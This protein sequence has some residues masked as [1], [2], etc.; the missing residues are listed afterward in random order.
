ML[1]KNVLLDDKAT[2]QK[3]SYSH[4]D[5]VLRWKI[6]PDIKIVF[7]IV[8]KEIL[9]LTLIDEFLEMLAY[10]FEQKVWPKLLL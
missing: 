4:S 2:G 8:Y 9:Q 6:Q 10:D 3:N 1:I 7:A 5:S